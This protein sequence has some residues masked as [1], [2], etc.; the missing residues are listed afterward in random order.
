MAQ[1][2]SEIS[3]R[4]CRGYTTHL[5]FP[6]SLAPIKKTKFGPRGTRAA[7]FEVHSWTQ[8][9]M[10]SFLVQLLGVLGVVCEAATWNAATNAASRTWRGMAMSTSGQYV[11]A[12]QQQGDGIYYSSNYGAS[13]SASNVVSGNYIYMGGSDSG[14]YML[15]SVHGGGQVWYSQNYGQILAWSRSQW[16]WSVCACVYRWRRPDLEII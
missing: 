9:S 1:D 2:R 5:L 14:Q 11:A 15:A 6:V 13:W 12:S 8:F 3:A 16:K 4:A 7:D 10:F